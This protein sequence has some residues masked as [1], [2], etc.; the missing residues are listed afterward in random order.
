VE[1]GTYTGERSSSRSRQASFSASRRSVLIRLPGYLGISEGATTTLRSRA[2]LQPPRDHEPAQPSLVAYVQ[3]G[4]PVAPDPAQEL[5]QRVEVVGDRPSLA[6]LPGA[7]PF[8]HGRGDCFFVD[9][10]SDVDF[11]FVDMVC[12]L[13]RLSHYGVSERVSAHYGVVLADRPS[14]A[15]RVL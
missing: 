11:N 8:G 12:L 4:L 3:R 15:V 14:Q 6:R 2:L 13:I 5:F 10:E 7:P 1:S 9:I